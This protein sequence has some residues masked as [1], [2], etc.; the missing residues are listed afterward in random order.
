[1]SRET[2]AYRHTPKAPPKPPPDTRVADATKALATFW[3]TSGDLYAAET[4]EACRK[5]TAAELN[6][7]LAW[8]PSGQGRTAQKCDRAREIL[9]GV[10][11]EKK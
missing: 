6:L 4:A 3:G 1:M 2:A 9:R 7:V 5:L 11:A 8:I 10:I